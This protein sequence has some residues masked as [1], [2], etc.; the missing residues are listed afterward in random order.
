MTIMVFG[1][2]WKFEG[3]ANEDGRKPS[4]WDTFAHGG[5]ANMYEGDGDIACDGYHKYKEDVELMANMGLDAYRF[6]ISWS[7]LIPGNIWNDTNHFYLKSFEPPNK[8][9][10]Q[11]TSQTNNLLQSGSVVT[12]INM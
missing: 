8:I 7:R 10:K 3:A 12:N 6:S 11:G 1:G 9:I 2:D 5:N 4:I